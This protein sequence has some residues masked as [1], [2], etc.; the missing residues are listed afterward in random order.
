MKRWERVSGYFI[1]AYAVGLV[2][3]SLSLGVGSPTQPGPGFLGFFLGLGLI[4]SAFW[5]TFM[6]RGSNLKEGQK[7]AFWESGTWIKPLYGLGSL[8]GFVAL[9]DILGTILT[10]VLF[11]FLWV[12]VVEKKD[13][14]LAVL[15][16]TIGTASFYMIFGVLLGVPLPKGFWAA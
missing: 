13:W 14:V 2:Y 7:K 16:A 15:M 12:K 1:L 4:F 8:T 11:F 5:L 9:M 10:M 3:Q 6:N